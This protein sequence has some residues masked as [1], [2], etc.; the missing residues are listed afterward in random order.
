MNYYDK[1]GA[2]YDEDAPEFEDRYW[3][4][5]T[6]QQIRSSFREETEKFNF[7]NAFEI[8]FGPGVDLIY[9]GK[10]Y[11][12]KNFN[13]IDISAGMAEHAQKQ[14]EKNQLENVQV[15]VGSVEDIA[16]L[17][18]DKKYDLIFVYFGALNTVE[19]LSVAA[20]CLR[21]QLNSNGKVVVTVINKWYWMGMLLPLMKL[22]INT[23][24]KRI[25]KTW[26]G[27][28]PKRQLESKCYA[29]REVKRAFR[30]FKLLRKRGYSILFPAWY[31][32]HIR[33]K[34][35]G[36]S[37]LLWKMDQLINKTPFWSKGEYT[38]FVFEKE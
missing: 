35:G 2:Y 24:F 27:Y 23:A 3:E 5:K 22:K 31:Q 36:I 38:L 14:I 33:E 20:E 4:N 28:S 19:D 15:A 30:G 1:V 25:Q 11:P 37:K 29:P 7:D 16:R 18:P 9:F 13:G 10:K 21:K 6:L 17:F 8:G 12:N 32:D 26:G 34:L